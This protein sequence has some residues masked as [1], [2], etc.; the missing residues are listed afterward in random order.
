M[1]S[2]ILAHRA[3]VLLL[4][5]ALAAPAPGARAGLTITDTETV[6]RLTVQPV[7]APRPALRYLLLPEYRE[8][9]PGNPIPAYLRCMLDE[10]V[11]GPQAIQRRERLLALPLDQLP[12][13]D[14]KDYGGR[15]LRRADWAARLDK[16]DWHI[17][18]QVKTEGIGL[19]LPD[20]QPIR[21]LARA[22]KLRLRGEVALHR[23]DDAV[24]TAKTL[25]ALSRHTGE[26][27]I[28]VGNV[29]AMAMAYEAIGPL[30]EMLEQPACPNLYWALTNLPC[31]L[32][33]VRS[34]MHGDL[35]CLRGEFRE[36][37]DTAPMTAGQIKGFVRHM[38]LVRRL[39]ANPAKDGGTQAYLHQR[40]KDP[41]AVEAARRR[42]AEVGYPRDLVG[43]FPSDQ[44]ILLDEWRDFEVRRDEFAKLMNL[45]Y[46]Q[47]EAVVRPAELKPGK[48]L[49]HL[50]LPA[51]HRVR[52]LQGRLDQRVA[53][54]RHVEALR[55]YS[56][57]HGGKLPPKLADVGVPLPDDPFTGKPFSYRVDGD[58]AHLRGSPPAGEEKNAAYNVRY[59]VTIR[60]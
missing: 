28:L 51:L 49:F 14:L 20:L 47:I 8:L 16:P 54:L 1:R 34:A 22:L 24:S 40:T 13:R 17:M 33:D 9:N 59:E 21:E 7:A 41:A 48:G 5:A 25:F 11:A 39:E 46:W 44:V 12:A 60:R 18:R 35:A 43:Q 30:E 38:D 56:A 57:G 31:P 29:V 36:M 15:V 27:P 10:Y 19:L 2:A 50:L 55:L 37:D 23:Y 6:V 53:L 3:P 4:A 58:T 32:I 45:P 26:H 52:R 42:L